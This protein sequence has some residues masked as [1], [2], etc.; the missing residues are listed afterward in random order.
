LPISFL[1]ALGIT[2]IIL[3]FTFIAVSLV[4][5]VATLVPN[6]LLLKLPLAPQLL[7]F[8]IF[9]FSKW[10]VYIHYCRALANRRNLLIISVALSVVNMAILAL[11]IVI[12]PPGYRMV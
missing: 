3:A 1:R 10:F 2:T 5:F 9:T 7:V 8:F 6:P 4:A 12:L 11:L